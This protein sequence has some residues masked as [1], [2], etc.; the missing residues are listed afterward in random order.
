MPKAPLFSLS[1][2]GLPRWV[3]ETDDPQAAQD[4]PAE[5]HLRRL[6]LP[7]GAVLALALRLFDVK[8][9]PQLHHIAGPLERPEVAAWARALRQSGSVSLLLQRTGW[10]SD[11]E[12]KVGAA[13]AELAA[14]DAPRP[15]ATD[16]EG[17]I[18]LYLDRYREALPRLGQPEAVWDELAAAPAGHKRRGVPWGWIS[19][20]L[21]A[22]AAA[23]GAWMWF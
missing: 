11:Y 23:L 5:M 19:L 15:P 1:P 9:K 6:D 10:N 20:G 7:G 17:A 8:R 22:A 12:R 3:V 14:L 21:L 2:D 13:P 4:L 16:P 18:R